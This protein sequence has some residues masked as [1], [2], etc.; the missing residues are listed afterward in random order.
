MSKQDVVIN[1]GVQAT[2]NTDLSRIF[3]WENRYASGQFTND[4]YDPLVMKAGK[5]LGRVAA[6]Q[7]LALCDTD[8][9]DGSQ[10]P[11]GILAEDVTI[12]DG[13]TKTV[14]YCIYG[15]VAEDKIILNGN[16]T[17]GSVVSGQSLRDRIGMIGVRIIPSTEM[18]AFDNQ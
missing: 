7:K 14:S 16:D 6:T 12:E 1:T 18:T 13:E 11:V 3:L 5:L 9:T 17:L 4:I 10:Y 15:D 2:I 8:S